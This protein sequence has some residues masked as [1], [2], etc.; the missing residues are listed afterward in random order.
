MLVRMDKSERWH[1]RVGVRS[2]VEAAA[3][4]VRWVIRQQTLKQVVGWG[5]K[6]CLCGVWRGVFLKGDGRSSLIA[7]WLFVRDW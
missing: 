6:C 4:L 1:E 3:G 5:L 7:R 2:S